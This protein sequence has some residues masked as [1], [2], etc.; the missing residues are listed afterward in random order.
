MRESKWADRKVEIQQEIIRDTEYR[1]ITDKFFNKSKYKLIALYMYVHPSS[2]HRV[3]W[4]DGRFK[5]A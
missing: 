3:Y 2:A 5:V 4:I 1:K